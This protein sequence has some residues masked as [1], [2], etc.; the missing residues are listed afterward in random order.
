MKIIVNGKGGVGKTSIVAGLATLFAKNGFGVLALDVDS[1]PNLAQSLGIPPE[2]AYSII[3]LSKN[4]EL[5]EER[6]GAKPGQGWGLFFSLTPKVDDLVEKYGI[7]IGDN[8]RLVVIGS[9]DSGKEGCMCPAIALAKAFLRHVLLEENELVI[10]DSEAGLEVFGRGLAEKFD[11]MIC[12]S[13]P[14]YKS[15][16][17]SKKMFSLAKDLDIKNRLLV[18]NKVTDIDSALKIYDNVFGEENVP[19]HIVRFDSHLSKI[20]EMGLGIYSLPSHSIFLEDLR[21]LYSRI[22]KILK[23]KR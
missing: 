22:C 18:I 15:M 11:L 17:A 16:V 10:V 1:F 5:V 21:K 12:V 14:T 19:Y 2:K 9:I 23:I 3:P 7:K 4:E 6:T 8:I 20:E 13:E